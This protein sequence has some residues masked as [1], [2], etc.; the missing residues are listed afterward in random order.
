MTV[1]AIEAPKIEAE[2]KSRLG[3]D[4]K[5]NEILSMLLKQIKWVN[6]R[7]I[8]GLLDEKEKLQPEHYF[9]ICADEI[10]KVAKLNNWGL[11]R[12]HDFIYI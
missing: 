1:I 6:F 4:T 11:C 3:S 5:H 10:L 2:T 8:A 9:V 7:N 12:N